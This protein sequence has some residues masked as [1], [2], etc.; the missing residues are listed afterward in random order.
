MTRRA[1]RMDDRRDV[2]REHH[3]LLRG[4][5]PGTEPQNHAEHENRDQHIH[6]NGSH[7][8]SYGSASV[9]KQIMV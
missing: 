7:T 3:P 2:L 5:G 8:I 9:L 1:V 6:E 4:E